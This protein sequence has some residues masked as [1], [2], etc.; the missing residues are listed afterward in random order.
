[1]KHWKISEY[2]DEK[3]SLTGSHNPRK[4]SKG[5]HLQEPEAT[6]A[7]FM[8]KRAAYNRYSG[9]KK[10]SNSA[11]GIGEAKKEK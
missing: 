11:L 1:M 3:V 7:L 2:K 9:L 8:Q 10:T 4:K 5:R 6:Q